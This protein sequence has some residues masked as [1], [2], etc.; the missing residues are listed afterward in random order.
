MKTNSFIKSLSAIGASAALAISAAN[1]KP[2]KDGD[3]DHPSSQKAE[4][5]DG[6]NNSKAGQKGKKPDK[7][8]DKNN[9]KDRQNAQGNQDR[10]KDQKHQAGNPSD[11]KDAGDKQRRQ[12]KGRFEDRDR[13]HVVTYFSQYKGRDHGL[14]P[15]LVRKWERGRRLP[16]AWRDRVVPGYVIHDDW[17]PAFEPVPYDWFPGITVVADTRLYWYG[18]RVVRVYEPTREVVDVVI[19]PTIH[20]DL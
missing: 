20:I 19:I 5:H 15:G 8:T 10:G 14:P 6:K 12:F 13:D 16:P 11:R 4:K 18:D 2:D 17:Y 1:A 9:K 3:K 7:Q